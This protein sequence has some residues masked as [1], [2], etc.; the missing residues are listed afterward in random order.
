M[1]VGRTSLCPPVRWP[2]TNRS[3]G[4]WRRSS[5]RTLRE[6]RFALAAIGA[7]AEGDRDAL[8]VLRRTLRRTRPIVPDFG[9]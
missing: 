1:V 4:P 9:P 3:A 5:A 8:D 6:T 2:G 7:L